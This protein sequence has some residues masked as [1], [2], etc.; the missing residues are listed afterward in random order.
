LVSGSLGKRSHKKKN[1]VPLGKEPWSGPTEVLIFGG[2]ALGVS[3]GL[4]TQDDPAGVNRLG[5][6]VIQ[7]LMKTFL[8]LITYDNQP[9]F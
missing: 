2:G 6:V 8:F 4:L 9:D 7:G 3:Q 5:S 1:P